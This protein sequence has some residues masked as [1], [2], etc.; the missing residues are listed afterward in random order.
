MG[1]GV[2]R[3]ELVSVAFGLSVAAGRSAPK[4]EPEGVLLGV[5]S[6]SFRDRTLA[7]AIEAMKRLGVHYCE[8]GNNHMEP[9]GVSREDLRKWRVSVP[10]SKFTAARNAFDRAGIQLT[11]YSYPFRSDFVEDELRRGFEM[12]RALG[13]DVITSSANVSMT[14][15]IDRYA[16]EFGIRV[17]LHNHSNRTPDEFATPQDFEAGIAGRSKFIGINLDTGHFSAAGFD[18]VGFLRQHHGGTF[19]VHLKDR[20]KDLGPKTPFG[21][22]DTPLVEVLR[23]MK[24]NRWSIPAMIEYEY[25]GADTTAEVGRCL[26]YCRKALA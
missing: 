17:G 15:R 21:E 13:V 19:S 24:R 4:R 10:L 8:L 6:Y 3:R 23:L 1:N 12:A 11:G 18:P 2:S 20:K 5:Q 9:A 16:V 22:G 26:D 25:K 7:R 14:P